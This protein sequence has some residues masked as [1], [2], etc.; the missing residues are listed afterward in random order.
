MV[1]TSD[2]GSVF[3]NVPYD[4]QYERL[5][6][7]LVATLVSLGQTPRCVLEVRERGQG[8]LARI[9]DLLGSC[10]ISIHDL[11]RTGTPARFNMPFELGLACSLALA[12][13]AHDVVV[14]DSEPYR[15]DRTISDYKGRDP[16][17]HHNRVDDLV[18]C[19][20]DVFQ[21]AREPTPQMLKAEARF[22]RKSAREIAAQYGGTLFRP[23]AFRALIAASAERARQQGFIPP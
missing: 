6:A 5:F 2:P 1:G 20:A 12:G 15:L 13:A 16:L 4:S 3:L 21:V 22:L 8:R 19:I 11:S 9:Y 7:T 23:A 14:L 17:I 18:D 10:G